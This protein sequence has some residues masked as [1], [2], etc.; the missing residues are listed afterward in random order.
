MPT[1][2][3]FSILI[4]TYN[5]RDL[6][7]RTLPTVFGQNFAANKYEVIVVNDGSSDGTTEL[8]RSFNPS[9]GFRVIEQPNRGQWAALNAALKVARGDLVLLID[10]DMLCDRSVLSQHF[11]AHAREQRLAVFGPVLV[12]A[13]SAATLAVDWIRQCG[14]R[15]YARLARGHMPR[16]HE[17]LLDANTSVARS[18]LAAS[19]GFDESFALTRANAEF[20]LRLQKMGVRLHFEVRALT[21]QMLVKSARDLV[22]RDALSYGRNEVV[23]CRKHPDFRPDSFL[24]A[25]GAGRWWK[26]RARELV[27]RLPISVEPLLRAP[28]WL[29][30]RLRRSP[31]IR[32][33]GIRTLRLRQGVVSIRAA[34]DAAGSWHCLRDDFGLR[35]PVLLYHHVGPLRPDTYPELTISPHTFE[36]QIAW[37]KDHG[38]SAI[39]PSQWLQWCREGSALPPNPVMITFDDA[40]YDLV[41]YALPVLLRYGLNAAVFVVTQRIGSTNVWDEVSGSGTHRL[42]TVEHI[43]HWACQ[44]IEFGAHSRTHSDLT[45][46]D[47]AELHNEIAGSSCD[48]AACLGVP[49]AAFA[50]PYG[51][52]NHAVASSV[53]EYFALAFTCQLGMNT[54][55]SNLGA[56]RRTMVQPNDSLIGFRCRATLGWSPADRIRLRARVSLASRSFV[57]RIHHFVIA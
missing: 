33:I 45:R 43:R 28:F 32:R 27:A 22:L 51:H 9:C 40:Y 31:S 50:Y 24:A 11:A 6:L 30:E 39:T 57:S 5:R 44:G 20:G 12:S 53:S 16:P 37:L 26:R 19:G 42:M 55:Q 2:M 38:Y 56:L 48:L 29:A 8:L 47:P 36:R 4:P 21:F 1:M 7:A 13:D 18:L 46:L 3:D 15:S 41:E 25:L 34:R 10:D 17:I 14:E 52:F 35:L 23:L 54:L 49:P